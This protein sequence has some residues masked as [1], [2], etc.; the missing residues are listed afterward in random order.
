MILVYIGVSGKYKYIMFT[1]QNK[2]DVFIKN[3]LKL[4]A[5]CD[6]NSIMLSL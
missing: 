1:I 5:L 6:T 4:A 2:K 3:N